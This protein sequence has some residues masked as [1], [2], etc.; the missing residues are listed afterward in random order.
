MK[1]YLSGAM[2][3][4]P[5]SNFPAF[6]KA[7][8]LL[9]KAGHQVYNPTGGKEQPEGDEQPTEVFT[10]HLEELLKCDAIAVLMGW[11]MSEGAKLEMAVALASGK[12]TYAIFPNRPPAQMLEKLSNVNIITR[13]EVIHVK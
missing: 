8:G 3:G 7:S 6:N 10:R 2:R 5:Q 9:E 4:L 11:G 12:E 1:F 13:A